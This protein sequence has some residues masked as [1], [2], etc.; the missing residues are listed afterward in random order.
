MRRGG[1]RACRRDGQQ[2]RAALRARQ[3]DV[4][5]LSTSRRTC[6]KS[7]DTVVERRC[8]AAEHAFRV[9]AVPLTP[10]DQKRV[11]SLQQ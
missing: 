10:C 6:R 11:R 9:I 5:F 3:R 2:R 8:A 7:R 1:R 4:S